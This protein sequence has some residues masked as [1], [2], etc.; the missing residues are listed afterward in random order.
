M[1]DKYNIDDAI[2]EYQMMLYKEEIER[3]VKI[4]QQNQDSIGRI[5]R[6]KSL[7]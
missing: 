1:P 3:Y 7:T 5:V 4:L 6:S 2:L